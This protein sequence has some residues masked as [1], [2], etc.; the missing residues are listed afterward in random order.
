[1]TAQ[2]IAVLAR[3]WYSVA[4]NLASLASNGGRK[5]QFDDGENSAP[6]DNHSKDSLS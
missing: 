1:M 6:S 4:L 5:K 2:A 3:R